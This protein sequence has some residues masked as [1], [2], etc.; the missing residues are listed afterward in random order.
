MGEIISFFS[1]LQKNF[2]VSQEKYIEKAKKSKTARYDIEHFKKNIL[3]ADTLEKY[4]LNY[5]F[6]FKIFEINTNNNSPVE[7]KKNEII[8]FLQNNQ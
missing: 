1:R 7:I 5:T 3:S 6:N 8:S 4:I 2:I